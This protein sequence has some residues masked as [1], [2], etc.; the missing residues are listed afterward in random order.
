MPGAAPAGVSSTTEATPPSGQGG[1][2][3]T[4]NVSMA[5]GGDRGPMT[6]AS[7]QPP[8][9]VTTT[10]APT[11]AVPVR[12]TSVPPWIGPFVGCILDTVG[13]R[14][15][16]TGLT[17]AHLRRGTKVDG[18]S[19]DSPAGLSGSCGAKTTASRVCAYSPGSVDG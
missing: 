18:L 8:P 10:C 19:D 4:A 12:V 13:V 5:A 15:I 3:T 6:W 14:Q 2:R 17:A 16:S 9:P 11:S 1:I 7:A